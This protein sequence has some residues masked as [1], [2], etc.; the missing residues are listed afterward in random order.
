MYSPT[1]YIMFV[2]ASKLYVTTPKITKSKKLQKQI[3]KVVNLMIYHLNYG[4]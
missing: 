1:T 2:F 3:K 4:F